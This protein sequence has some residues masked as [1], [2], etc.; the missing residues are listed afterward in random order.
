MKKVLLLIVTVLAFQIPTFAQ[1]KNIKKN[2]AKSQKRIVIDS[3]QWRKDHYV[4]NRDS[5]YA[6]PRLGLKKLMGGN[7]RFIEGKSIKP[8]QDASTIKKLEN[9]QAPF[10]TIVGCSDS[11]V[12]NE[13]IF[14]QGL[15]DLL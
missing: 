11:R 15:G 12:P 5:A 1:S 3:T 7:K 13:M 10:A 6:D 14:D 4:I 8:R 2:A 9:G